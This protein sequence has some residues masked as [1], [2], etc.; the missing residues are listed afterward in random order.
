MGNSGVN[1]SGT[2]IEKASPIAKANYDGFYSL[3]AQPQLVRQLMD[4]RFFQTFFLSR[5]P[6]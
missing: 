3:D 5:G 4:L 2:T 1:I 6:Q